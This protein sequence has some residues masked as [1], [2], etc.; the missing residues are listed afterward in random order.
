MKNVSRFNVFLLMFVILCTSVAGG[1][2]QQVPDTTSLPKITNPAYAGGEGPRIFIDGS[3]NNFHTAD[4]RY[5][6]FATFLR[7]DGFRV[8]GLKRTINRDVLKECEV[9]V[10]S[11]ALHASNLG[12]WQLPTPSAFSSDEIKAIRAWVEQGGSLMLI[13]DHMP[14]PGAAAELA[15]AF[16]VQFNNGFAYEME[17]GQRQNRPIIFRRADGSLGEHAITRGRN[18]DERIDSVATFTGQAFQVSADSGALLVFREGSVSQMPEIAWQ[19]DADTKSVDVSGWLQGY[20]AETG[21][22]RV[23]IFGEAAMFTSQRAGPQGRPMGMTMPLASQN[24][25]FLLNVMHWL[26]GLL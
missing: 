13:A 25:Q 22:G 3:H 2:C 15:A 5:L 9:L 20:V 26:A 7:A 18:S 10:I 6:P 24:P 12:N 8:K 21:R 4:N 17:N 19:F 11:N 14:F 23:A 1:F 16:G